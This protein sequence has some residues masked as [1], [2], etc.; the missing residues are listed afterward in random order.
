M[1]PDWKA[2]YKAKEIQQLKLSILEI[3]KK[4]VTSST[5]KQNTERHKK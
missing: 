3:C 2:I 4:H 5:K 1:I